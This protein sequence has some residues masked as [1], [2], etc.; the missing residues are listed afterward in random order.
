MTVVLAGGSP[1][2]TNH[3]KALVKHQ[4]A[5]EPC[6]PLDSDWSGAMELAE[7]MKS[8]IIAYARARCSDPT[9]A[10]DVYQEVFV[11]LTKKWEKVMDHPAPEAW[12]MTVAKK[13]VWGLARKERC[14]KMIVSRL[15]EMQN[16]VLLQRSE[17]AICDRL[18]LVRELN[19]LTS[20]QLHMI[21]LHYF[22]DYSIVE[23]AQQLG[24]REGTVKSTLYQA[25]NVLAKTLR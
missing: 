24:V 14:S 8:K 21:Y 16:K 20:R 18:D 17:G 5:I 19:K 11:I 3:L 13:V 1:P 25:R 4:M 2:P 6:S 7:R 15:E 23:I 10:D 22:A 9:V 12:I